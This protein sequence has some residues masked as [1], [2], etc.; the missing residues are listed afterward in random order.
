MNFITVL[1]GRSL[2]SPLVVCSIDSLCRRTHVA[3][4]RDE[5]M[6]LPLSLPL[7]LRR[8][9]LTFPLFLSRHLT[10]PCLSLGLRLIGLLTLWD[11]GRPPRPCPNL[12]LHHLLSSASGFAGTG[13][14]IA[15]EQLFPP[16]KLPRT[17]SLCLELLSPHRPSGMTSSSSP[18]NHRFDQG[19]VPPPF[20]FSPGFRLLAFLSLI[21]K[22]PTPSSKPRFPPTHCIGHSGL[23]PI[24][25]FLPRAL[26]PLIHLTYQS[27]YDS[28][29]FWSPFPALY[30]HLTYNPHAFLPTHP[31][32]RLSS[33]FSPVA[34][35]D[36]NLSFCPIAQFLADVPL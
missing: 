26:P 28:R 9:H 29:S 1:T 25:A 20:P 3:C 30:P 34:P 18:P 6:A 8:S 22:L 11:Y 36:P 21:D 4:F 32:L 15:Y 7:F 24:F 19:R 5:P 2:N 16:E 14:Q 27:V 12:V 17:S 13:D 35:D 10:G 31:I 33:P 23:L